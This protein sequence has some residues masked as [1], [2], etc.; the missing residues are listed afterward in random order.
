MDLTQS[1]LS[2]YQTIGTRLDGWEIIVTAEITGTTNTYEI[3]TCRECA[4]LRLRAHDPEAYR[5]ELTRGQWADREHDRG[6]E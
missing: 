3:R 6:E 2:E 4:G 5:L 1:L